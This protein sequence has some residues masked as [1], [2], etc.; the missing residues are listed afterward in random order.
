M[1]IRRGEYI[2]TDPNIR[3]SGPSAPSL[4]RHFNERARNRSTI[5]ALIA[6]AIDALAPFKRMPSLN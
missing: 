3:V 4:N 2:F 6:R 1:L 5:T